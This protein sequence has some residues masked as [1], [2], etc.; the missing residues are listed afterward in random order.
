MSSKCV[1]FWDKCG[2]KRPWTV[3]GH[4]PKGCVKSWLFPPPTHGHIHRGVG[5]RHSWIQCGNKSGGETCTYELCTF[6]GSSP[7]S[8]APYSRIDC[9]SL[10]GSAL[11]KVDPE[12]RFETDPLLFRIVSSVW[13]IISTANLGI[14]ILSGCVLHP[15]FST[16]PCLPSSTTIPSYCPNCTAVMGRTSDEKVRLW[17]RRIMKLLFVH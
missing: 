7:K 2:Q 9:D 6:F 4:C 16:D 12:S 3:L 5:S 13:W 11:W 17:K 15:G 14:G 1:W 8:W 10:R